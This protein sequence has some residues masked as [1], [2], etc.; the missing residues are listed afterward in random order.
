MMKEY[1]GAH[2]ARAAGHKAHPKATRNERLCQRKESGSVLMCVAEII[3]F[4]G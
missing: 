3:W 1:R 4:P 2:P